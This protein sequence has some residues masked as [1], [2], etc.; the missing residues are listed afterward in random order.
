MDKGKKAEPLSPPFNLSASDPSHL[1]T[2]ADQ[3]AIFAA[4]EQL[5]AY[6]ASNLTVVT[7]EG[8]LELAQGR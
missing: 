3:A 5:V 1:R 4:Y 2:E 8:I 6:A 7:S